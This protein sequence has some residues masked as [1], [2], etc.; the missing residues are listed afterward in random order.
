[1][2]ICFLAKS[3]YVSNMGMT[4]NTMDKGS[5]RVEE[6][7]EAALFSKDTEASKATVFC[8]TLLERYNLQ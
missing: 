7:E 3:K 6:Q 1:M 5:L 4:E 2:Q 8:L